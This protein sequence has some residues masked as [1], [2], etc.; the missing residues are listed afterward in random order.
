MVEVSGI[1]TDSYLVPTSLP[2]TWKETF[3]AEARPLRGRPPG[4]ERRW[5]CSEFIAKKFSLSRVV[6]GESGM[7]SLVSSA[8]LAEAMV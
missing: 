1:L 6:K 2:A 4:K 7:S 8:P 5:G 3:L